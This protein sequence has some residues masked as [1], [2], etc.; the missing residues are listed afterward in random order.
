MTAE[1]GDVLL[2]NTMIQGGME[3][4]L[5]KMLLVAATWDEILQGTKFTDELTADC[6]ALQIEAAPEK[7]KA[8][9]LKTLEN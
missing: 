1:H 7:Y 6:Y 5:R 9:K 8:K 2:E 4:E 3:R